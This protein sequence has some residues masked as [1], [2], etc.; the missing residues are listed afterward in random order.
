MM[1]YARYDFVRKRLISLYN[2]V[3]HR[4]YR[5]H[6]APEKMMT[7]DQ[8]RTRPTYTQEG[9]A[10]DHD[11]YSE[12][13]MRVMKIPQILMYMEN[14]QSAEDIVFERYNKSVIEVYEGLTE[15]IALWC[16]IIKNAPDF[17]APTFA[18]LRE[19]ESLAYLLFNVYKRIKPF[20]KREKERKQYEQDTQLEG[21]GLAGFRALFGMS[22]MV[23]QVIHG[24]KDGI[25]FYS[26]LDELM[27]T[28]SHS[29]EGPAAPMYNPAPFNPELAVQQ[30]QLLQ[31][32]VPF[33][34]LF[35]QQPQMVANPDWIFREG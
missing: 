23:E 20:V 18:E 35:A 21:A 14:F 26:P 3:Q 11:F 28:S 6:I 16:E 27:G 9:F 29:Y 8:I 30:Q 15:Y 7:L 31:P 32:V 1:T 10:N 19:L 4:G 24:S 13:G 5:V 22:S 25:S 17:K 12:K 34:T 33:D 2:I